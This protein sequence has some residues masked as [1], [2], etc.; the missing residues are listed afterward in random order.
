MKYTVGFSDKIPEREWG[1]GDTESLVETAH[2]MLKHLICDLSLVVPQTGF[3][4]LQLFAHGFGQGSLS[5][6]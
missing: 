3:S 1:A 5:Q 2:S 4:Q 6:L